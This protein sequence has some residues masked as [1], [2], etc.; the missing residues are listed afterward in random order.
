MWFDTQDASSWD[1]K[2]AN[3]TQDLVSNH[4]AISVTYVCSEI[5]KAFY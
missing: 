1:R 5:I 2:L 4:A 3:F